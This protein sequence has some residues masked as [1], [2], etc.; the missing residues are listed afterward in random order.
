MERDREEFAGQDPQFDADPFAV[1]RK[2]L[3]AA[4]ENGELKQRY[5]ERLLPL[6]FEPSPPT[7]E[8]AFATFEQAFATFEEVANRLLG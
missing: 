6:V 4:K 1:L 7:F 5:E 8:Q 3:M 2:T